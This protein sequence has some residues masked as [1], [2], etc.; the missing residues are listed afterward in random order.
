M[1]NTLKAIGL[2]GVAVLF[3]ALIVL[4]YIRSCTFTTEEMGFLG[5]DQYGRC[6]LI[7]TLN[8]N[9]PTTLF[10]TSEWS[11]Y[12]LLQRLWRR[13]MSTTLRMH[14]TS[15]KK[16]LVYMHAAEG[17]AEIEPYINFITNK[18]LA[19]PFTTFLEGYTNV[20]LQ[21]EVRPSTE[22]FISYANEMGVKNM[23][24]F[25]VGYGFRQVEWFVNESKKVSVILNTNVVN[26]T[27]NDWGAICGS[28]SNEPSDIIVKWHWGWSNGLLTGTNP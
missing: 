2:T 1:K 21:Y 26:T 4:F 17:F 25:F 10:F 20:V 13:P 15:D 16:G 12:S 28:T 5:G 18:F 24:D 3:F 9:S 27:E 14:I 11:D 22:E 8:H 19:M 23:R 6:A 7:E